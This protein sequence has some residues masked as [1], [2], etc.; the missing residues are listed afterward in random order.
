MYIT[1]HSISLRSDHTPHHDCPSFSLYL[2]LL[3]FR[4]RW[5][6]GAISW[7]IDI[8]LLHGSFG[9]CRKQRILVRISESSL[10][11][12]FQHIVINTMSGDLALFLQLAFALLAM[13]LGVL[14]FALLLFQKS[15]LCRGLHVNTLLRWGGPVEQA[16]LKDEE[17]VKGR[18][19][20]CDFLR[21]LQCLLRQ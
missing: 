20:R 10:A 5:L 6:R 3:R 21:Q 7:I 12:F 8:V 19:G 1:W 9:F 13:F 11:H 16:L 4:C 15:I 14:Q 17:T 18:L 2:L